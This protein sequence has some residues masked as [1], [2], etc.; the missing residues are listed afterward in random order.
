MGPNGAGKSTLLRALLGLSTPDSGEVRLDGQPL[1][2]WTRAE[3]SAA[4]A[5]LA[6]GRPFLKAPA[7]VMWWPWGAEPAAGNGAWFP[8]A[9]GRRRTRRPYWVL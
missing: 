5:Y 7:C 3:R 1:R 9:P 4:L 6:Q 2:H 8:P